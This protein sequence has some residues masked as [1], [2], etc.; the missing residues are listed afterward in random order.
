MSQITRELFKG[1]NCF[2]TPY[3]INCLYANHCFQLQRSLDYGGDTL[4]HSLSTQFGSLL[5]LECDL[6]KYPLI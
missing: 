5:S 1:K 2:W 3:Y 6:G 4:R